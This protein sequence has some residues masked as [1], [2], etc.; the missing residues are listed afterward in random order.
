MAIS[1]NDTN[2]LYNRS[3]A[4]FSL[5]KT[6]DALDSL[7]KCEEIAPQDPRT[8]Y[9]LA[10]IYRSFSNFDEAVKHAENGYKLDSSDKEG[11]ISYGSKRF[12]H[13]LIYIKS[14]FYE[15]LNN[16]NKRLMF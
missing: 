7:L 5:G 1:P 14:N 6:Q 11:L 16:P 8:Q 12:V 4:L 9:G 15:S 10:T 13:F 3:S 2:A